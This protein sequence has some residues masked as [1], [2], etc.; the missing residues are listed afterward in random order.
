MGRSSQL[1]A[2]RVREDRLVLSGIRGLAVALVAGIA[3]SAQAEIGVSPDTT[4]DL[5]GVVVWQSEVALDDLGGGIAIDD[6]GGLV[7]SADVDAYHEEA[8]GS[9]LFS[10]DVTVSLPGGVVAGPADVVRKDG[11]SFSLAFDSAS[12]GVAP[13]SNVDAVSR[14]QNDDLILSFATAVQLGSTLAA[15]E[16]LI[17]FDGADFYLALEGALAGLGKATDIDAAQWL[18]PGVFA[19]SVDTT[20]SIEGLVI[21]DEDLVLLSPSTNFAHRG[22]DGSAI[23]AGWES[24]DLV[25]VYVPEPVSWLGLACGATCLALVGRSKATADGRRVVGCKG[26]R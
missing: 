25:A 22:F 9:V 13:G 10:T 21:E 1:V 26:R 8:D 19:V 6:L 20:T 5:S 7:R 12:A 24:A 17:G 23:H 11:L 16:D 18:A 2:D 15:D 4:T 14:G 3:A